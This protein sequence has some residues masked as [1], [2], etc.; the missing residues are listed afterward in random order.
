MIFIPYKSIENKGAKMLI[1]NINQQNNKQNFKGHIEVDLLKIPEALRPRFIKT[2]QNELGSGLI[3]K[4]VRDKKHDVM[5]DVFIGV[6]P[7]NL[8]NRNS[9]PG[10]IVIATGNEIDLIKQ[11]GEEFTQNKIDTI[12]RKFVDTISRILRH[13]TNVQKNTAIKQVIGDSGDITKYVENVTIRINPNNGKIY[14]HN[15][16]EKR[17]VFAFRKTDTDKI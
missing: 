16:Q 4:V 1:N 14:T 8:K 6:L 7:E 15:F 17:G 9:S 10:K 5:Q 11:R 2:V 13:M 12:D 3:S